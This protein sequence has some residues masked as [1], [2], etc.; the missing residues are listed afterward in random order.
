MNEEEYKAKYNS[1]DA[2]PGWDAIDNALKNIYKDQEPKHWAAV[3]H[4]SIGG[5]DPIDGISYY[6]AY[7]EGE[8]YYH[9]VTYGF[10]NLYYDEEYLDDEC[11]GYGFELTFRL[12]PFHLDENGP[13]WVFQLIQNI[14][15]YV[16]KSGKW[17]E[18]NHYMPANGQ[19]R[20]D[21]DT[22]LTGLAFL[23][24]P[25]LGEINTP[26]GTLQ[27]L[28]MFGI[29][30]EELNAITESKSDAEQLIKQHS[31]NNPLLIT[32]LN[33]KHI[34][35][36]N[37]DVMN[38][39]NKD[40][41]G[42]ILERQTTYSIIE[43]QKNS[44][45]YKISYVS[46]QEFSIESENFEGIEIL[47][48]HPLLEEYEYSFTKLYVSTATKESKLLS[49]EIHQALKL[50]YQG[51]RTDNYLNTEYN[52]GNILSEG[53]G[54]LYSGPPSGAHVVE[55]ILN[56]HNVSFN[57]LY[58][59]KVKEEKYKVLFLGENYIVAKDF[60]V[61]KSEPSESNEQ[62]EITSPH[63]AKKTSFWKG[64]TNVFKK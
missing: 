47:D 46:K 29:I 25:E 19:I 16:F 12:T 52:I 24:D 48:E 9:F 64:L 21:S 38:K 6:E 36:H 54:M 43:E 11:S 37:R 30:D 15:R 18:P 2:S 35:N 40:T 22:A 28:Q 1:E 61:E 26:H 17:F 7:H 63:K 49:D 32:D 10:S 55:S 50:H 39:F 8:L 4:Y 53:Q 51:W 56:N 13:T 60:K 14:A 3:P 58:R 33:R 57:A 31:I 27:F 44:K 20:T 59:G 45:S 23:L 34:D 41:K 62:I 42:T 5:K